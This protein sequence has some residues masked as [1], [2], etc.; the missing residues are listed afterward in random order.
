MAPSASVATTRPVRGDFS[1]VISILHLVD[2]AANDWADF[3]S[4]AADYLRVGRSGRRPIPSGRE[5]I[6][7][8]GSQSRKMQPLQEQGA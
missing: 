8:S 7:S 6:L 3:D 4:A 2:R 1:T 5:K